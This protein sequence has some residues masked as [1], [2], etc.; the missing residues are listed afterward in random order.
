MLRSK[1]LTIVSGTIIFA[2]YDSVDIYCLSE[3]QI[4]V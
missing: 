2:I 1:Y 4:G 3:Q